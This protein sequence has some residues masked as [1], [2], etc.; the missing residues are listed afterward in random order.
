MTDVWRFA[1]LVP[2]SETLSFLTDIQVAI[3]AESR[4]SMRQARSVYPMVHRLANVA[5]LEAE[6]VFDAN[7]T[8]TFKVPSWGEATEFAMPVPAG[9]TVLPVGPGDWRAGGEAY[10]ASPARL[11]EVIGIASVGSGT[12]TLDAPTTRAAIWAAPVRACKALTPLTGTRAFDGLQDRQVTFVSQDNLDLAAHD[13]P[14]IDDLMVIDDAPVSARG[15]E[16]AMVHPVQVIDEGPGGV[17][18]EPLRDGAD[19]RLS[20]SFTDVGLAALWRRRQFWHALRGRA[21]EFWLPSF[22]RDLTLRADVA[23]ASLTLR[24]VAPVWS[25]DLLVGRVLTLDDGGARVHRKVTDIT[26]DGAD[27]VCDLTASPGRL[28]WSG[29]R[30]SIARRMRLDSDDITLTFPMPGM[31]VSGAPCVGVP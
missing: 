10:L 23:A 19:H 29:A 14:V 13:M 28:I 9:A 1:P 27:W 2:F 31:M 7:R 21:T 3:L 5:N 18:I 17:V 24:L 20:I 12:I 22:V 6:G 16:Q 26:V 25:P 30:V 4:T 8:S 11:G 15:T